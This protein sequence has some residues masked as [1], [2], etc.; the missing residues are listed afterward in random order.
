MKLVKFIISCICIAVLSNYATCSE[1]SSK[2]KTNM[3]IKSLEKLLFDYQ[4][5]NKKAENVKKGNFLKIKTE[6]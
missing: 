1:S 5:F 3:R 6:L 4:N 2:S